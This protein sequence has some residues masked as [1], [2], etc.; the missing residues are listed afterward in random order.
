MW[1]YFY[2]FSKAFTGPLCGDDQLQDIFQ[3]DT[4]APFQKLP[5]ANQILNPRQLAEKEEGEEEGKKNRFQS[6]E[7]LSHL[8]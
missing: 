1:P 2:F 3:K 8:G 5:L 4:V 7:R 6:C